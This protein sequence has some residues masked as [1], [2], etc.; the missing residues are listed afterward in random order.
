M[1]DCWHDIK[2]QELNFIHHTHTHTRQLRTHVDSLTGCTMAYTPM[3]RFI[4]VPPP[5]PRSDWA[6][7]FGKPWW[8]NERY[9]IGILSGKTRKIRIINSLTLQ[10]QTV[11]VHDKSGVDCSIYILLEATIPTNQGTYLWFV[12]VWLRQGLKECMLPCLLYRLLN[13]L[14]RSQWYSGID[15]PPIFHCRCA[16]KRLWLKSWNATYP[17]TRTLPAT[18]GNTLEKTLKWERL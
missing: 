14:Y 3:G 10:E 15:K 5:C 12:S 17:T 11:E 8:K 7:N 6:N 1:V 18:H 2:I 13:L 4:H 9:C 16:L